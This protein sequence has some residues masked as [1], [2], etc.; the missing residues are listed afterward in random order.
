MRKFFAKHDQKYVPL[1]ENLLSEYI[2][3][4]RLL[5]TRLRRMYLSSPRNNLG[6][7]QQQQQQQNKEEGQD[8]QVSS[9]SNV[10][11]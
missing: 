3:N 9:S 10:N 8:K 4:E 11:E 1:V 7:R 5:F 6:D 2:G